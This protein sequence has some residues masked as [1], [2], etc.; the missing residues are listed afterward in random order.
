MG[1]KFRTTRRVEFRDTDAAGIMH[2]SVYI[3]YME[4]AE[5]ELL[6]DLGLS[7]MMRDAEG[8][9]SWPRVSVQCDYQGT[10]HFED[11]LD[12]EVGLVRMGSKSV[13]YEFH[14]RCDDQPLASG[15]MTAVCCRLT[16]PDA[17]PISDAP[18]TTDVALT[19]DVPLISDDALS[20]GG[21]LRSI[22]VPEWIA[23]KLRPL[24]DD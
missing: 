24:I 23:S 11:V 21:P 18:L 8:P 15:R 20:A 12:I 13:T 9:I 22:P 1:K 10:A 6:R 7:V 4:E 17:P 14:F 5:H 16:P 19:T 3:A 2:F